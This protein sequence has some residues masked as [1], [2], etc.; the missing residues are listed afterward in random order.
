VSRRF[1][2]VERR[3]DIGGGRSVSAVI[4]LP[5]GT[6]RRPATTV[7]LAHG[8]GNDMH[9]PFLSAV[10]EGL[11]ARG[12]T[13]VKFN[14]PY[15]EIGRRAPD[16]APVLEACYQSVLAAVRADE[17]LAPGR[18]VI[19]GKSLGGRMATHLAA[20]GAATAG[21]V[22]L[23]YPLHPPGRTDKP[24]VTHLGRIRVP[25]LFFAGTRDTLCQLDLLRQTLQGL[26]VPTTLH[27]IDGGDHSFNLPK[28]MNRD[29][30]SVWDEIVGATADWIDVLPA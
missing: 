5:S 29:A 3:I 22:L 13:A 23:G 12:Y 14:F 21:V 24:R 2:I 10:H 27:V 11:A 6:P 4:A 16:P 28:R 30:R 9:T 7:I 17:R 20:A 18:I 8:A 25:M 1:E 19:G 26:P 15:T